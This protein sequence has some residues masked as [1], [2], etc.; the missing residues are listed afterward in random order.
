MAV[1]SDRI[2]R[3]IELARQM[4]VCDTG[5]VILLDLLMDS[6][7]LQQVQVMRLLSQ[8]GRG[9]SLPRMIRKRLGWQANHTSNVL[10]RLCELGLVERQRVVIGYEYR[11]SI[12]GEEGDVV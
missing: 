2:V 7:S 9:W 10:K 4:W 6:L 8:G 11:C 12:D 5:R 3:A 1:S